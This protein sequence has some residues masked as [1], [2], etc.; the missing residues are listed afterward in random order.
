MKDYTKRI[1]AVER[2][3]AN[4]KRRM[5]ADMAQLEM[6][7]N[8][9][10]KKTDTLSAEN[11]ELRGERGVLLARHREL[12]QALASEKF[13]RAAQRR[14]QEN[15]DLLVAAVKEDF[16]GHEPEALAPA[17]H[18]HRIV[19][20]RGWIRSDEAAKLC[21]V[22]EIRIGEWAHELEAQGRIDVARQQGKL[23]LRRKAA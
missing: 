7:L 3:V 13:A 17:D 10:K 9:L 16:D 4:V 11:S 8:M 15:V 21:G 5:R 1:A 2:D 23:V 22:H 18:L 20:D 12:L 14:I 6:S 19:V